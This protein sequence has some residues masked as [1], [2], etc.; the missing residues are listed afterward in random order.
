[1]S[2][3][4]HINGLPPSLILIFIQLYFLARYFKNHYDE[5][6]EMEIL[7]Q[8]MDINQDDIQHEKN[9]IK[10][11]EKFLVLIRKLK[12]EWEFTD[13][14]LLEEEKLVESL[15]NNKK[16]ELLN[17]LDIIQSKLNEKDVDMQ[18]FEYADLEYIKNIGGYEISQEELRQQQKNELKEKYQNLENEYD[19]I[20]S[21]LNDTLNMTEECKKKAYNYILNNK[22]KRLEN[23]YVIEKTPLGNVLMIYD[24]KNETFKYY[25]DNTIP[26]RYLEVVARKYVKLFDCRPLYIDMEEELR[27]T[28]EK[29]EKILSRSI[30]PL[31]VNI[32]KGI[33]HNLEG[34]KSHKKDV[35]AK[36]K[37]YNKQSSI[38]SMPIKDGAIREAHKNMKLNKNDQNIQSK[39]NEKQYQAS[40]EKANRYTYEGKFA[41]F[42][43]LKK[44]D[45]KLFNKKLGLSFSE[46]KSISKRPV[47]Y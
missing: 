38:S 22:I 8:S 32:S 9:T 41:N 2:W 21:E 34:E 25:S 28:N 6:E 3:V 39:E 31:E 14:E 19:L 11:E 15:L 1:M 44:V 12:K 37:N 17:K 13:E 43:F 24:I 35:F 16:N 42:S 20:K 36:L 40:K 46:F 33:K 18:E 4:F 29:L 45:K 26:Y 7:E 47:L 23:C 5:L 27:L 30:I 10:Y